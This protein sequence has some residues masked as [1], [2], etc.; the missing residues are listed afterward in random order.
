MN[1]FVQHHHMA[2]PALQVAA[3]SDPLRTAAG[4]YRAASGH[5]SA[6]PPADRREVGSQGLCMA[7]ALRPAALPAVQA[8]NAAA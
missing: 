2:Q 8:A 1:P 5:A 6:D 7:A 4:P 3:T